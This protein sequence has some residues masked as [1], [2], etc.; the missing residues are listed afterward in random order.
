MV[1][2]EAFFGFRVNHYLEAIWAQLADFVSSYSATNQHNLTRTLSVE[3]HRH[4]AMC[5]HFLGSMSVI[6]SIFLGLVAP[7][8][9]MLNNRSISNSSCLSPVFMIWG[10][11]T[12]RPKDANQSNKCTPGGLVMSFSFGTSTLRIARQ[13]ATEYTNGMSPVCPEH[14][15]P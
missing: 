15:S 5:C 10:T 6:K 14:S 1:P 9:R 8:P 11:N 7:Q 13:E 2:Q 3:Y 4:P 12:S